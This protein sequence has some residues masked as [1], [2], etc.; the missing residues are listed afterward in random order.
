MEELIKT[1]TQSE[2]LANAI[3][4]GYVVR[5]WKSYKDGHGEVVNVRM[6]SDHYATET[7][8]GVKANRNFVKDRVMYL[9]QSIVNYYN[10]RFE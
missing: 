3:S 1:I 6:I 5:V 10:D 9:Y 4:K 8:F 2:G 7:F